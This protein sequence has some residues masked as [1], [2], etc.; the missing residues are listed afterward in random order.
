MYHFKTATILKI[1]ACTRLGRD[2]SCIDPLDLR[3]MNGLA[4]LPS[5]TFPTDGFPR[6]ILPGS[7]SRTLKSL[8]NW[9]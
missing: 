9:E 6:S 3:A 4:H 8:G 2:V 7:A 1:E 5:Q